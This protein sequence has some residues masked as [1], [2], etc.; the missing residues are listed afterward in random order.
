MYSNQKQF[1]HCLCKAS[2]GE[3]LKGSWDIP[4]HRRKLSHWTTPS[5]VLHMMKVVDPCLLAAKSRA[6][7]AWA[8]FHKHVVLHKQHMCLVVAA[9]LWPKEVGPQSSICRPPDTPLKRQLHTTTNSLYFHNECII[10]RLHRN[11]IFISCVK[12]WKCSCGCDFSCNTTFDKRIPAFMFSNYQ[13]N[14]LHNPLFIMLFS[15]SS[16]L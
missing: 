2:H 15:D 9:P 3:Q 11:H 5:H 7:V 14:N 10:F 1:N 6:V 16:C 12:P 4:G 13:H 8:A